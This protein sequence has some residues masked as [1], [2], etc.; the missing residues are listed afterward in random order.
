MMGGF[1]M[2]GYGVIVWLLVI[3]AGIWVLTAAPQTRGSA[4]SARKAGMV[5]TLVVAP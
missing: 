1:G 5:G 4:D 3:G 2:G